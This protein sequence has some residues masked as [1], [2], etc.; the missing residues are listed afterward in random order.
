[1]SQVLSL[2]CLAIFASAASADIYDLNATVGLTSYTSEF[3]PGYT[4]LAVT[5]TLDVDPTNGIESGTIQVQ[6][7]PNIF[8]GFFG[9]PGTCSFYYN[10]GFAEYGFLDLGVAPFTGSS[11]R[12][13]ADSNI[14]LSF[15]TPPVTNDQFTLS[16]TLTDENGGG[17]FS[18]AQ[19]LDGSPEAPEPTFF[20]VLILCLGSVLF[21]ARNRRGA[22]RAR[23]ASSPR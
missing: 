18:G 1:M 23:M 20:G 8:T 15:L 6:G 19:G 2:A 13:G 11:I 3:I 5:G 14:D 17:F 10:N 22:A 4:G 16:G 7:D 21:I 12:L 9:C